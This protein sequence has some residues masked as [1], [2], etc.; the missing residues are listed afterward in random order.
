MKNKLSQSLLNSKKDNYFIIRKKWTNEF[1]DYFD[2][3]KFLEYIESEKGKEIINEY[4]IN[5]NYYELFLG[6][7]KLLPKQYK[8]SNKIKIND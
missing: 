7:M 6:I 4:N 3:N 2:Y 8:K 5:K 1:F